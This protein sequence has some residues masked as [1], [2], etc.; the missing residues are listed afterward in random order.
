MH[1]LLQATLDGDDAV[2]D[3]PLS[4]AEIN[5][6]CDHCNEMRMKSKTAQERCDRVFLSLYVLSKPMKSELGVVLSV[7]VKTFLVYIPS[8]GLS[9]ML[10]L[11]EHQD[12]LDSEFV[13]DDDLT[14]RIILRQKSD[15]EGIQWG[16]LEIK[17]FTKLTVTVYCRE[18]P[19]IDVKLKLEG[20]WSG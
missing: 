16:A 10:F 14:R 5:Q 9:T 13:E 6:I 7:G 20:P 19:P 17:V 12:V 11:D 8:L 15:I 4:S 3:F 2:E 1:R 18:K